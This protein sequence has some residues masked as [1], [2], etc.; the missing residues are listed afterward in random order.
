MPRTAAIDRES[1]ISC[2]SCGSS[3]YYR[4][5]RAWTGKRRF[6]CLICNRQFTLGSTRGRRDDR[7]RCP[8]CGRGM[9]VYKREVELI[10]YRC[11][12]YPRCRTFNKVFLD[13]SD[14]KNQSRPGKYIS[15]PGIIF[16]P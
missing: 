12:G 4:Y 16:P 8:A 1:D 14:K 5:G 9:H 7:P 6:L 13:K 3:A 10:R 2:P 11:S 15:M